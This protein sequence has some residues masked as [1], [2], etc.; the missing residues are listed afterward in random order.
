MH[1]VPAVA[2]HVCDSVHPSFTV[3]LAV[4]EWAKNSNITAAMDNTQNTEILEG[5]LHFQAS[6]VPWAK[7]PAKVLHRDFTVAADSLSDN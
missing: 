2:K 5:M 7:T 4:A 3:R 6:P 1:F